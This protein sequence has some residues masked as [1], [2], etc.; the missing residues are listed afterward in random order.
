M[1]MGQARGIGYNSVRNKGPFSKIQSFA[2]WVF[3]DMVKVGPI[4]LFK[5][6]SPTSIEN[7]PHLT[8]P[9]LDFSTAYC[10]E[11]R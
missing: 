1:N 2:P 4:T 3:F 11:P 5:A 6:R 8:P 9:L 7:L 10:L